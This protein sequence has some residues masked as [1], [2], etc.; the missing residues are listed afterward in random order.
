MG[1][2]GGWLVILL[3]L[4][5]LRETSEGN[6]DWVEGA[7]VSVCLLRRGAKPE[8]LTLTFV[9]VVCLIIGIVFSR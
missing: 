6:M 1:G 3:A 5:D 2:C 7:S 9:V 8:K 4:V